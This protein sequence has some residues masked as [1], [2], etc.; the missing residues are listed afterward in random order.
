[1]KIR[2]GPGGMML[3]PSGFRNELPDDLYVTGRANAARAGRVR[4]SH[5]NCVSPHFASKN[6]P[7]IR[8]YGASWTQ[9]AEW[10]EDFGV[11]V[12]NPDYIAT[13]FLGH[14]VVNPKSQ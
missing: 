5:L 11:A 1:M 6:L 14:G 3:T 7:A 12:S 2:A 9:N 13:D 8:S 10:R 4:C